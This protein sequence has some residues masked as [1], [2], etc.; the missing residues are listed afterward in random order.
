MKEEEIHFINKTYMDMNVKMYNMSF[1]ILGDQYDAEKVVAETFFKVI[2][3]M[4]IIADLSSSQITPYCILILKNEII[5]IIRSRNKVVY[6]DVIDFSTQ[7]SETE[8]LEKS[9][10]TSP[11]QLL[12]EISLLPTEYRNMLFL[13]YC[14]DSSPFEIDK[15]L[16]TEKT[17]AKLQDLQKIL[18]DLIGLENPWISHDAMKTACKACLKE[19]LKDYYNTVEVHKPNYLK[20][21][22][23]TPEQLIKERILR[24]SI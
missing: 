15:M 9:L 4:D 8:H 20:N 5:K 22:K 2:E 24:K 6:L 13:R 3:N 19:E 14:F 17:L 21:L 10:E 11:N 23:N 1:N 12:E 16:G 18:S 7:S